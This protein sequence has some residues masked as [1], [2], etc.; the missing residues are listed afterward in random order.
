M[1]NNSNVNQTNLCLHYMSAI[2]IAC[3]S[4]GSKL[5]TFLNVHNGTSYK[6][7][8]CHE[9]TQISLIIKKNHSVHNQ[10]VL[11]CQVKTHN[12]PQCSN[13]G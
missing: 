8:I 10:Y 7:Y 6:N 11:L 9:A 5:N 2:N 1:D 4:F 12:I 13:T 3:K